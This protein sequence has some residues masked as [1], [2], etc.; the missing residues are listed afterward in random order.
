MVFLLA[1]IL[2]FIKEWLLI[3]VILALT[4]VYYILSTI[5]PEPIEHQL[6]T[7][8]VVTAGATYPWDDLTEFYFLKKY[9]QTLL[10]INTKKRFP[11]RLLLLIDDKI[12][13]N[14]KEILSQHL[15]YQ[16]ETDSNFL[17]RAADWLGKRMPW[18]KT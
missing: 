9:Q 4:F 15:L 6:T 3:G 1:V 14:L 13:E 2:F 12:K 16:K 18:E 8:G 5:P 17:D 10:A 11:G 7:K